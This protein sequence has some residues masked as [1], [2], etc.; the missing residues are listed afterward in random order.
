MLSLSLLT[1]IDDDTILKYTTGGSAFLGF[2]GLVSTG[3][4]YYS[5]SKGDKE[6]AKYHLDIAKAKLGLSGIVGGTS[7]AYKHFVKEK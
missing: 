6:T 5:K 7:L 1:E 2:S 3:L 4:G